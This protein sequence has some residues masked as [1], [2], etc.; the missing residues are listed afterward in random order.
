MQRNNRFIPHLQTLTEPLKHLIKKGAVWKWTNKEETAFIKLKESITGD[1]T[2]YFD[3]TWTTELTVDASPVG[4]GCMLFQVN[5]IDKFDRRL[6]TVKSRLLTEVESRYSQC[7][8]EALVRV[9]ACESL[10][11][12]LVGRHFKLL[13]DNRAVQLIFQPE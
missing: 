6:V 10:W 9:W 3:P 1:S 4:L 12:Y 2:A 11:P 8:K 7:E 13:T 5:P